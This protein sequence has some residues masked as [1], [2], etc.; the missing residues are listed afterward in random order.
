MGSFRD[1]KGRYLDGGKNYKLHVDA[2]PPVKNFWAVTAYD[3]TTRSLLEPGD[4]KNKSVGSREKPVANADGSVDVYFGAKPPKGME[5]NWV[6]S[7]PDKGFFLVFRFYGPLEGYITKT[8]VLN[9]LK[10][11]E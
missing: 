5:K 10:L 3:P 7:N 11:V 8:W 9:D 1:N 2:N 6:P 4:Y